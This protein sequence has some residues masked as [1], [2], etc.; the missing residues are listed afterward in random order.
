MVWISPLHIFAWHAFRLSMYITLRQSKTK[1]ASEPKWTPEIIEILHR[2]MRWPFS[3]ST[4]ILTYYCLVRVISFETSICVGV[5]WWILCSVIVPT[6]NG[7]SVLFD[8]IVCCCSLFLHWQFNNIWSYSNYFTINS[9]VLQL[10]S[11]STIVLCQVFIMNLC[12]DLFPFGRLPS[13]D[14]LV[15][16][17]RYFTLIFQIRINHAVYV[18]LLLQ[19][20]SA[21]YCFFAIHTS[22]IVLSFTIVIFTSFSL[23]S[24][25]NILMVNLFRYS[26]VEML[27]AGTQRP[28]PASFDYALSYR[29]LCF[30]HCSMFVAT[31]STI[32]IV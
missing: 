7:L 22:V 3:I 9:F 24:L 14:D 26:K 30:I 27:L 11:L 31:I 19:P 8:I 32:L 15:R 25:W 17:S 16:V 1:V 10:L 28:I 13:N 5:V 29:I 6:G 21:L 20:F 4:A 23:G 2:R 18:L 12:M